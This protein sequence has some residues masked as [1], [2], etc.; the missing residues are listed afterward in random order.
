MKKLFFIF[1]LLSCFTAGFTQEKKYT[2]ED[3]LNYLQNMP[4]SQLP[5]EGKWVQIEDGF[6]SVEYAAIDGPGMDYLV[7]FIGSKFQ[8]MSFSKFLYIYGERIR[9]REVTSGIIT[10]NGYIRIKYTGKTAPAIASDGN[11]V[12]VPIFIAD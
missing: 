9:T 11:R 2:S 5:E 3:L 7:T 8:S 6:F 1:V 4:G 12:E 10:I